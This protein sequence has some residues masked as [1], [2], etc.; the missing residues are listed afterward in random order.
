VVAAERIGLAPG[1]AV[2][3]AALQNSAR[4]RCPS[5]RRSDGDVG[6]DDLVDLVAVPRV[7]VDRPGRALDIDGEARLR[8]RLVHHAAVREDDP[9]AGL[10]ELGRHVEQPALVVAV[11]PSALYSLKLAVALIGS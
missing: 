7:A 10:V 6:R 5:A 9:H 4:S 3:D 8:V 1:Q 11:E 2:E